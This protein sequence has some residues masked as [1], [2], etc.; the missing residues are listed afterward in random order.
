MT[1]QPSSPP[2]G[3]P[4]GEGASPSS[5]D[6]PMTKSGV[7][8]IPLDQ[9]PKPVAP[10]TG[11]VR[12]EFRKNWPVWA[13]QLP[14]LKFPPI[15]QNFQLIDMYQLDDTLKDADPAVVKHLREELAFLDQ[16][17]LRFFRY[18][19]Y[20]AK[21]QQNRYRLFQL[22]FLML[23]A[24]A[25]LLGSLQALALSPE[26][27]SLVP[28]LAF[29]ATLVSLF[30]TFLATISGREPPMP[31]WLNN[32]RRA[33]SLRREYFRYLMNMSPYDTMDGYKRR[34]LLSTRAADIN[35]GVFPDD[36]TTA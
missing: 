3:K 10:I 9:K 15:N 27:R 1:N 36:T 24:L 35:R 31:A 6:A 33:E 13:Q 7:T 28:L 17:L 30:A 16:E 26:S 11:E 19:D 4:A 29:G 32:R 34:V 20:E 14:R 25:A 12:K 2:A 23:A 22:G 18:R 8:S 21:Q 5:A